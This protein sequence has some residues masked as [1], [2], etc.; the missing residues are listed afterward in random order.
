MT[1]K[2]SKPEQISSYLW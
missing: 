1:P 2:L